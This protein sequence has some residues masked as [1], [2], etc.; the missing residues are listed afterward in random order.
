MLID[1]RTVPDGS[2]LTFDL[3]VVGAG[4]A[5]I[6]MADRLRDAGLRICLLEGGGRHPDLATQRL[7]RGENVGHPY[8]PLDACRFRLFGGGSNRWG[9]WC[10]PLEPEDFAG[11][12][13]PANRWPIA[14]TDLEPYYPDAATLFALPTGGFDLETW[15][16]RMPPAL[17][18]DGRTFQ[19]SVFLYS[20]E[21]NFADAY[22]AR[23]ERSPH[24]STFIRANVTD[25][26]LD[27][28]GTRLSGVQVRTLAGTGFTVTARA[29]VLAAGG[30]ENARLLLAA[31]GRRPAGLGNEHDLVGRHFMEHLHVAAGHLLLAAPRPRADFYRKAVYGDLRVRGV[32]TPTAE[33]RARHGLLG[34]SIAIEDPSYAY[35]T[36]FLGWRPELT[37]GPIRAYRGARHGRG[38]RAAEWLKGTSERAWNLTRK[39][40][41]GRASR[42]VRAQAGVSPG[43]L[44]SLYF[45]TEQAPSPASRVTLSDRHRDAL[46]VP[47]TRLDWRVAPADETSVTGWL[48]HLDA[49]LRTHGLGGVIMPGEGWQDGVIG[50]PHHMGTTRMSDDPRHGV[51]DA[52]CRVHSVEGLYVAGSSVFT[53]GGYANP[54]F[55]LVALALRLADHL[56]G[57]LR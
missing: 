10:R 31:R 4:P 21:L 52:D 6:A 11:D 43:N 1:A 32:I 42:A 2:E 26:L 46:G 40:R 55:T 41:T 22:A 57:E 34:A 39:L 20:P 15:A 3:V 51:V 44:R 45:R 19:N 38:M 13:T 56:A 14:H 5:G 18:F 28:A 54:T 53:T 23:I 47:L 24:V 8:Y 37:F 25:L 7:Y 48:G 17:P 50:G 27:D 49:E 16:G 35:G 9:G 12:G 36:P 30:I 33:A 29:T